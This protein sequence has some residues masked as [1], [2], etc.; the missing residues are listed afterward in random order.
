M[1]FGPV[2]PKT[3]PRQDNGIVLLMAERFQ[4]DNQAQSEWATKAKQCVDF[5]EGRQWSEQDMAAMLAAKRP[6]YTFNIIAPLM[7]LVLG[8]HSNNRTDITFQ[9]GNNDLS[10]EEIADVMTQVEKNVANMTGQ[11]FVDTTVL[12]DGLFTGRGYFDTR[13]NFEENDL[14]EVRTKACDPFTVFPD[15]DGDTY[16]LNESCNHISTTKWIS[17]DE[18]EHTFGKHAMQ[19]LRP[20]TQNQT[21][22]SPASS[23]I[24]EDHVTPVRYFGNRDDQ[25]FP[26][27]DQFYATM[28]T[29]VDTYRKTLRVLEMQHYVSE[30]R[31]VIIDLETGDKKI[32]P[33]EWKQDKIDKLVAWGQQTNNPL[34]VER[35]KVRSVYWTT[36][37]ADMLMYHDRSKY[38]QFTITPYFPYFRRGMTRGAVDDLIDPQRE[39]NK[40]RSVEIEIASK[41]ANG[42]WKYHANALTNSQK[43]HLKKYGSSPGFQFE[44]GKAGVQDAAQAALLEPKEIQPGTVAS[45]HDRLEIKAAEDLRLISGIN[46]S[47][48]GETDP[49]VMSG[50]AIEARQK[51]AVISIQLYMDN[52]ERSKGLLGK[53]RLDLYQNYYSEPRIFRTLGEDG[54]WSVTAINQRQQMMIDPYTGLPSQHG[55]PV[56]RIL[57]DI[58]IGNYLVH[59]EHQPLSA[60]FANAQFDEMMMLL[61][62]MGPAMAQHIPMFADLMLDMSSMPRK[63]EWIER[64]NMIMGAPPPGAPGAPPPQGALPAPPGQPIAA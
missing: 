24:L 50:R 13:L 5:V 37:I 64:F 40:R 53:R 17:I 34:Y 63:Q 25:F 33:I 54:K 62:K 29:F 47:A 21:P 60:T 2:P 55:H 9:P 1:Y 44:W 26:W 15:A 19:L 11:K 31:N 20:F 41:S 56:K 48:L 22:I 10:S 23:L 38:S 32:L 57:N 12:A 49:K 8:Y 3:L 16:D 52:F 28:G 39:K 18:I 61:E 27:W 46:E 59:I 42:G 51:Q 14:G 4:R 58:T 6:A 36:M 7:R 43:L 35:R 45:N 30:T